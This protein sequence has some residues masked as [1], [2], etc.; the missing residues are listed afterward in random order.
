[1]SK[2]LIYNCFSLRRILIVYKK[3]FKCEK[4]KFILGNA[5]NSKFSPEL[6]PRVQ[7]SSF[8]LIWWIDWCIWSDTS[9]AHRAGTKVSSKSFENDAFCAGPSLMFAFSEDPPAIV[10]TPSQGPK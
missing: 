5:T 1:V 2:K 8:K 9:K 6:D 4:E 10:V 3:T 7:S